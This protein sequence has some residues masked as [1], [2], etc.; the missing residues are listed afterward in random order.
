VFFDDSQVWLIIGV[1]VGCVAFLG[2]IAILANAYVTS[3]RLANVL[4]DVE[5]VLHA[6]FRELEEKLEAILTKIRI[7]E[8]KSNRE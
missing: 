2:V 1:I 6:D 3:R 5:E 8:A 7:A 4:S